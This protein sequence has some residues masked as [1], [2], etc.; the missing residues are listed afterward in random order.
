MPKPTKEEIY[1]KQ[2]KA[3]QLR[4]AGRNYDEIAAALQYAN[5]S[6]AWKA[7]KNAMTKTLREPADQIR[8]METDRLDKALAG[9]WTRVI[10]GDD[11]AIQT[12]I[13]LSEQRAKLLGLYAP[14]QT[15]ITS[16]GEVI[17]GYTI[18]ANP[19][20]WDEDKSE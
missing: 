17:K 10:K 6:V 13:R 1:Q 12:F 7:V 4:L 15:D 19:D 3:L 14:T 2:L 20:M 18:L 5:R 9:I 11:R 16:G 8:D